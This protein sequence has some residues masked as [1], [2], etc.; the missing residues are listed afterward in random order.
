MAEYNY[1]KDGK[2][3]CRYSEL[4]KCTPGQVERVVAERINP[5]LRFESESM[6]FGTERHDMWSA[7]TLSTGIVP[8]CFQEIEEGRF[9]LPVS[10]VEHEFVTE[11]ASGIV[12]HSRPDAVSVVDKTIID[13]KT[14]LDGVNGYEKNLGHYRTSK[15]ALFYAFQLALHDIHISRV[16]YLCEIWN[17][18]RTEIVGYRYV[19]RRI[20][21]AETAGM[22]KWALD[23]AAMLKAELTLQGV[24]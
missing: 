11:L 15:Q 6:K 8:N 3:H 14:V 13:Y 17:E 22:L 23:R 7:Q 2:L 16:V 21:L 18:H 19:E 9:L 20:K 10:H 4:V 24:A 5:A 12:V 1:P